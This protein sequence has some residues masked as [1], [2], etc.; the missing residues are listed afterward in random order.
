[1]SYSSVVSFSDEGIE[2]RRSSGL[3]ERVNWADLQAVIIRTTAHGPFLED[4]F[5]VLVGKDSGCVVPS[6]AA[7]ETELLERLQKLPG[8]DNVAFIEAM[9][10]VEER[11]FVC[12]ERNAKK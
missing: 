2:C 12:W 6:E 5:W 8:F 4:V 9:S 10:C 1:L 11:S 7:G 3:V